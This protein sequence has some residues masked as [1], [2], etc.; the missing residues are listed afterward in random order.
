ML[1]CGVNCS[2]NGVLTKFKRAEPAGLVNLVK[3]RLERS[4]CAADA[5][6]CA[7]PTVEVMI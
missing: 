1:R 3:T 2:K 7:G 6:A 4:R 5:F